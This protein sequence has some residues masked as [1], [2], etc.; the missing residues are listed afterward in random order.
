MCFLSGVAASSRGDTGLRIEEWWEMFKNVSRPVNSYAGLPN[1]FFVNN[2]KPI[3]LKSQL[4]YCRKK[5]TVPRPLKAT[6]TILTSAQVVE[7]SVTVTDNSPFQDY[8]HP[9][10]HTTRSTVTPGSKPFTVL[11]NIYLSKNL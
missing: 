2:L 11:Q 4:Y 8:P 1:A 9:D 7:T 5:S 10:D 6:Q 3:L